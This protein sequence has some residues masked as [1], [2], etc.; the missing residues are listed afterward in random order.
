[1]YYLFCHFKTQG[2]ADNIHKY[3]GV[4]AKIIWNI[5]TS[6]QLKSTKSVRNHHL[7][8]TFNSLAS[9]VPAGE[10]WRHKGIHWQITTEIK[11]KRI[12]IQSVP[13]PSMSKRS[14]AS[15]IS[16]LF[17]CDIRL[18]G[19]SLFCPFTLTLAYMTN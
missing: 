14:N 12:K 16:C 18:R 4:I 19:F 2:P 17:C 6:S 7:M 15:F 1:M 3:E 9:I 5:K 11:R 10:L 8:A 13:E